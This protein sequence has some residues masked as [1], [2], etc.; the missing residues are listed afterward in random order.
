MFPEV[1]IAGAWAEF[2][3][4]PS[5]KTKFDGKTKELLRLAV[6]ARFRTAIAS[7]STHTAAKLNGA[8]DEEIREA[9]AII[10]D[11]AALEHRA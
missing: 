9:V 3:I 8:T 6:A 5:A 7:T 11:R 10:C 2:Q 1:R 4:G